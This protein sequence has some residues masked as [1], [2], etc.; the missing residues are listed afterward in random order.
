MNEKLI[1]M[2]MFSLLHKEPIMLKHKVI[3]LKPNQW[4]CH[5]DKNPIMENSDWIKFEYKIK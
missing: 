5:I 3:T 2:L 4:C 1:L